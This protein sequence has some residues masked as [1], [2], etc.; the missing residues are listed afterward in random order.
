MTELRVRKP[1]GRTT[2]SFPNTVESIP[3]ASGK[4]DGQLCLTLSKDSLLFK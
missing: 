4:A 1:D 2:V 3:A